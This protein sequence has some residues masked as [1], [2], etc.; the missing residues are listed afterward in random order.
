MHRFG[1]LVLGFL[2]VMALAP[3]AGAT[4]YTGP[5]FAADLLFA[6]NGKKLKSIGRIYVSPSAMRVESSGGVVLV[7]LENGTVVVLL[8]EQGVYMEIPAASGMAPNYETSACG[9]HNDKKN[10]GAET[11]SGRATI[12]WRCI[13][14]S[15]VVQ[16]LEPSDTT[17]WFDDSLDFWVREVRDNGETKELRNIEVGAQAASLF[18]IPDGL[19]EFSMPKE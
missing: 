10:Q 4:E 2:G 12:K 11:V 9:G 16:G 6:E 13:G 1:K 19:S 15:T 5:G 17:M 3:A 8:L 7:D 14:Q 18:K